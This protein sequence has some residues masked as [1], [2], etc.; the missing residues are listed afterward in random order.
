[1]DTFEKYLKEQ[2]TELDRIETPR[3]EV[4]WEGVRAGLQKPPSGHGWDLRVGAYWRWSIAAGVAILV[5]LSI[6]FWPDGTNAPG[7]SEDWAQFYP[8]LAEEEQQFKKLVAEKEAQIQLNELNKSEF[9]YIFEEL[10]LLEEVQRQMKEDLPL[11]L[12]EEELVQI[13]M[14]Y[15]ERKIRILER[16]SREIEKRKRDENKQHDQI[17]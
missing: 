10:Q 17:L 15:Y 12:S 5:S 2:R 4:I 16:L 8:A 3:R 13:L 6:W 1:M 7:G 14:K 9:S 11:T